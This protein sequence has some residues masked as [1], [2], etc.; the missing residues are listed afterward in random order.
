MGGNY[1]REAIPVNTFGVMMM[2]HERV[3]K[4]NKRPQRIHEY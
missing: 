1:D 3:T 2:I 4:Q